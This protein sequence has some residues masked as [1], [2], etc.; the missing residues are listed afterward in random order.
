MKIPLS[1]RGTITSA[2]VDR[3]GRRP[4][5]SDRFQSV[6]R[7]NAQAPLGHRRLQLIGKE[8]TRIEQPAFMPEMGA[9]ADT[10]Q[11]R[12]TAI[13]LF[14]GIVCKIRRRSLRHLMDGALFRHEAVDVMADDDAVI[15]NRVVLALRRG[16]P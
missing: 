2:R 8:K 6:M 9:G 16:D 4:P 13:A 11:D 10:L 14:R 5:R 7:G 15:R 1:R 12:Q 3:D